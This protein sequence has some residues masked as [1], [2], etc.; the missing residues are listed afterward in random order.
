M[1][2]K[3]FAFI[4]SALAVIANAQEGHREIAGKLTV[5]YAGSLAVPFKQISD[6]FKELHPGLDIQMEAAGSRD[7]ARKIRDLKRPCDVLASADYLVIEQLLVPDYADWNICFAANE[8]IIAYNPASRKSK[9]LTADNWFDILMS[10]ELAFGRSSPDADPCGYRAVLTMQ[11]AEKYYK[12]A[13]LT[14]KM[15]KKDLNFSRRTSQCSRLNI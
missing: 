5:F 9:Q 13:G 1:R 14:E 2:K 11:L 6:E 3:L 8:M 12:R 10:L 7:C 4:L 15:L